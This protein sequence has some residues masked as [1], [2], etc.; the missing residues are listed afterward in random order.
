M[1]KVATLM[2]LL[3]AAV[4]IVLPVTSFVNH[5][6]DNPSLNSPTFRADGNPYPPL[7]PPPQQL[8]TTLVADGNPYPPLPPPQQLPASFAAVGS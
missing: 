8:P 5:S 7:P 2:A 6:A 3:L 1:K 4:L